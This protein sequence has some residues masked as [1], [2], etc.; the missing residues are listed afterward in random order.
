MG[1]SEFNHKNTLGEECIPQPVCF[2]DDNGRSRV[3]KTREKWRKMIFV[4]GGP[5]GQASNANHR[6][7][8]GGL[9]HRGSSNDACATPQRRPRHDLAWI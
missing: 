8:G 3:A 7:T 2:S 4:I 6:Q 1:L 5:R 9:R